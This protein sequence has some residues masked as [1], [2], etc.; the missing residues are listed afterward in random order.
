[1]RP[2]RPEHRLFIR[3]EKREV[4]HNI[5]VYLTALQAAVL[6]GRMR[7][8][9]YRHIAQLLGVRTLTVNRYAQIVRA[10]LDVC[11]NAEAL[12]WGE[13]HRAE[14]EALVAASGEF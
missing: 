6:L 1:M 14:L 9:S 10:K 3:V 8:Y 2:R 12:R 13:Q 4:V 11:T 5:K 7:G